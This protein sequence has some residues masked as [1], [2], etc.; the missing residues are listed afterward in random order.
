[1]IDATG[2]FGVVKVETSNSNGTVEITVSDTGCGFPEKD[3]E[4]ILQP[5]YSTKEKGTG[6][7]LAISNGIV[8]AHKGKM[9]ITSKEG[10]GARFTVEI[11]NNLTD[12]SII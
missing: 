6:L 2:S 7:G 10:A 12:E 4:K 8:E 3:V 9:N 11:P 5:F 1:M